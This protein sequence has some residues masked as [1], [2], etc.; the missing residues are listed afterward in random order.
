MCA[1]FSAIALPAEKKA[2]LTFEKSNFSRSITVYSFPEKLIFFPS[3]LDDATKYNSVIGNFFFYNTSINF[4]PTLP[5]APTIAIFMVL[6][7][8]LY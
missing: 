6:L 4:L 3:L 2:S 7:E 5:V 8:L 1:H